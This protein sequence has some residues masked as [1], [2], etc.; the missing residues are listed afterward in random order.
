[1]TPPVQLLARQD[2]SLGQRRVVINEKPHVI[3]EGAAAER[4]G[5]KGRMKGKGTRARKRPW[6]NRKGGKGKQREASPHMQGR[7]AP[8]GKP[9]P[10]EDHWEQESLQT[11]AMTEEATDALKVMRCWM[12]KEECGGLTVSQ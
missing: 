5:G 1:M 11:V 7:R 8:E 3:G 9:D 12:E 10:D 2:Q 6:K 4:G